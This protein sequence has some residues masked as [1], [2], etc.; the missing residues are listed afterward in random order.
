MDWLTQLNWRDVKFWLLGLAAALVA[1]H[2]TWVSKATGPESSDLFATSGLIFLAIGSLIWDRR[3]DLLLKSNLAISALGTAL[4]AWVMV[5]SL[6]PAGYHL[7]VSPF[8]A[9]VGLVLLAAGSQGFRTYWREV[10]IL[11]LLPLSAVIRNVLEVINLPLLTAKFS[12][13]GL[14]YVGMTVRREG[15][16]IILPEGRVEVYE[17]CSGVQSVIQMFTIAVIFCFM[18]PLKWS[19]R[20]W[21]VI[22]AVAIGFGVNSARVGLMALLVAAKNPSFEYWHKGGGSLIFSMISVAIFGLF[23]W[24]VFLRQPLEA[25]TQ[26]ATAAVM[27]SPE[28]SSASVSGSEVSSSDLSAVAG[29]DQGEP[30]ELSHD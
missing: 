27:A 25:V 6:S 22:V 29:S 10:V 26:S 9:G 18:F 7:L 21:S 17:A 5:R 28:T 23:C 12:T 8:V 14:Y 3:D 11:S 16:F 30:S 13:F 1:L 15:L 19:Q 4:I 24:T 2:L 20:V